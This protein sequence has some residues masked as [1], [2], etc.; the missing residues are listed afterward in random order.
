MA[1]NVEP[2]Q[3]EISKR[4]E[5]LRVRL[6]RL[7]IETHD[8]EDK[9]HDKNEKKFARL[10]RKIQRARDREIA[11]IARLE[12]SKLYAKN[13]LIYKLMTPFFAI[14]RAAK[15]IIAKISKHDRELHLRRP[16][17]SFVMTPRAKTKRG[18]A[19]VGGYIAFCGEVW[20][21][22][23]KNKWLFAKFLLLYIV[24]ALVIVGLMNQSNFAS[25]R[26]SLDDMNNGAVSNFVAM[27][28]GA[29]MGVSGSGSGLGAQQPILAILLLLFG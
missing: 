20:R 3:Y 7:N 6:S 4:E 12:N 16:H 26:K 1:K 17:R 22:I 19:G 11:K 18:I 2:E 15:F 13:P 14:G 5:K 29:L 28:S 25:L 8:D 9:L 24:L 21:V 27:F 10:E 23:S